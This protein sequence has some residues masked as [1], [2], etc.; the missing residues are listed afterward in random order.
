MA[1]N[2]IKDGNYYV[3]QSFMVKDLHLKG[4]QKD[5]YA[6]IYGFS[7]AENQTFTGSLQYLADW[8][9]STKQGISKVLKELE[10][11][12]LIARKENFING[13]KFV[14]YYATELY[15]MQLSCTPP[16]HSSPNNINNNIYNINNNILENNI[17][18][19]ILNNN[20]NNKN[21]ILDNNTF[22]NINNK[23]TNIINNN[24]E[25]IEKML[26]KE[27]K[28]F[29]EYKHVLLSEDELDKLNR[30]YGE[31]QTNLGIKYLDEYIEMKGAKYKSHYL[32]MKKWVYDALKQHRLDKKCD[33][34][35]YT[36]EQANNVFDNLDDIEI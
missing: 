34:R 23:N 2:R 14:E 27:K 3:V 24:K 11:Q 15:T 35:N 22:N 5:A 26:R 18:N 16:Q 6:I 32:V 8:T 4:L 9:N 31:T 33:Q 28:K 1:E 12:G 13:V 20:I 29:G 25:K 30:D 36:Y 21:N 7:Q 17:N 10:E 19:N